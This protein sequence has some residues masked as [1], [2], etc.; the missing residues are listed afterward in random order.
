DRRRRGVRR[1]TVG[2]SDR[3]RA[4][5][6]GVSGG[7][8]GPRSQG[9]GPVAG[10]GRVPGDR[11]GRAGVLRGDVA[12]EQELDADHADVGGGGG[13]H[14]DGTWHSGAGRRRRGADRGGD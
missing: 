13:G 9:V 12:A 10:G 6:R 5:G 2:Y 3:D 11:V 7:V 4:G 1:G 14:G 8:A